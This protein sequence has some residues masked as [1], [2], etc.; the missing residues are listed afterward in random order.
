MRREL[1]IKQDDFWRLINREQFLL[2][3]FD[4]RLRYRLRTYYFPYCD[5]IF[6]PFYPYLAALDNECVY[7]Q[8]NCNEKTTGEHA[9]VN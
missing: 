1:T 4:A 9:E 6:F 3:Y 8:V 2:H 5:H 7:I